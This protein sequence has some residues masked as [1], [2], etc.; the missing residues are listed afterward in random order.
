MPDEPES[1]ESESAE[2]KALRRLRELAADESALDA[3]REESAALDDEFHRRLDDLGARAS[4]SREKR[5]RQVREEERSRTFDR[6]TARGTGVGLQVAYMII[7]FPMAGL[8]LGWYLDDR[9]DANAWK[10]ILVMG[11]ATLGI[12]MA[13][14]TLNRL[15]RK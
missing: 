6:D 12:L 2:A 3:A 5:Q 13:L 4:Q 1:P 7:G 11:G 8:G 14:V 9:F 10:P 15:E